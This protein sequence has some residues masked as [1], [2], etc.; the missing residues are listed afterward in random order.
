MAYP[1]VF[2]TNTAENNRLDKTD[3]LT[4]ITTL[5]CEFYDNIDRVNPVIKIDA[6]TI[7]IGSCNYMYIA[8]FERYYYITSI[9]ATKGKSFVVHGHVDVLNSFK[10]DIR[11]CPLV[12]ARSSNMFNG[13]LVDD[14]RL[15]NSAP[16]TT[17]VNLLGEDS[18]PDLGAPSV[19]ILVTI[20]SGGGED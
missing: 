17:Y 19:P 1:V 6:A 3:Y 2:Y 5:N 11:N 9:E 20:G 10:D 16:L 18:S 7:D 8:E 14:H 12:A 13:Y 4:Q 15:W